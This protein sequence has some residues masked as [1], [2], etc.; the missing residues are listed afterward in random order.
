MVDDRFRASQ[1]DDGSWGYHG[2]DKNR[3]DSMTCAGLL[4]LAVGRGS[5]RKGKAPALDPAIDS[6]LRHLGQRIGVLVPKKAIEA[7]VGRG[8]GRRG[9]LVGANAWGDLYFLWSLERVG[10]IYGLKTIGGKEWY[11][12]GVP[13]IVAHQNPDGSWAEAFPGP[14][15]TC[16]ALLFLKRV[17]VAKDLTKKLLLFGAI[18]DPGATGN[19][20]DGPQE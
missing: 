2:K 17:N 10:M 1:N 19:K 15:D 7:G 12:W 3:T 20:Q 6:G 13:V 9:Q 16:F 8:V 14:P 11:P 5:Q 18:K 4:G